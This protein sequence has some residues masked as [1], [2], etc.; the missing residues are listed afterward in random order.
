MKDNKHFQLTIYH[1]QCSVVPQFY[2]QVF[3]CEPGNYVKVLSVIIAEQINVS[4]K[5]L[6]ATEGWSS[7]DEQ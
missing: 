3:I 6:S 5:V 2:P 7:A 4:D 1:C